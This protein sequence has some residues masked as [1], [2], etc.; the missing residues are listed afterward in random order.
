MNVIFVSSR[1]RGRLGQGF[2]SQQNKTGDTVNITVPCDL[3]LGLFSQGAILQRQIGPVQ[4]RPELARPTSRPDSGRSSRPD[5][6]RSART[7]SRPVSG[8][9][10]R[11]TRPASR[12]HN[13]DNEI[14]ISP[15]THWSSLGEIPT[16]LDLE[17][18]EAE[19][20]SINSNN[21]NDYVPCSPIYEPNT[22]VEDHPVEEAPEGPQQ[23]PSRE[24][25]A[26]NI[27]TSAR[28]EPFRDDGAPNIPNSARREQKRFPIY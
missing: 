1:G 10:P 3:V 26:P 23:E 13:M 14:P 11:M 27:T 7:N 28:R 21:D 22:P 5:S 24:D 19:V 4:L 16:R 9:S 2:Y 17:V 20:I 18:E 25:R 6:A 12:C 8:R 15:F